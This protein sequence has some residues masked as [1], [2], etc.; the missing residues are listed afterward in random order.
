METQQ[1]QPLSQRIALLERGSGA[2]LSLMGVPCLAGPS[3]VTLYSFCCASWYLWHWCSAAQDHIHTDLQISEE[4]ESTASLSASGKNEMENPFASKAKAFSETCSGPGP[5]SEAADGIAVQQDE[6]VRPFPPVS[7]SLQ[8][9]VPPWA[10]QVRTGP[11]VFV[12]ISRPK[13]SQGVSQAALLASQKGFEEADI[14]WT[15]FLPHKYV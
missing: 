13:C 3:D 10:S 8:Q 11:A 6:A 5:S 9:A 15:H 4:G 1:P 12:I 2:V 7:P 14:P